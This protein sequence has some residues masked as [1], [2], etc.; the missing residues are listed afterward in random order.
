MART[1]EA[2]ATYHR[3]K[4][5]LTEHL[6]VATA[7]LY[8]LRRNIQTSNAP[9][10]LGSFVDACGVQHWGKGKH[11]N[12]ADEKVDAAVASLAEQGVIQ[13]V[14]AFDL[15][16]RNLIQDTARFSSQAR[17]TLS[18][19]K[20]DHQLL[21]LSSAN[22][23]VSNHC[24][25]DLSGRLDTLSKRLEELKLWL[26]WAPSAKLTATLPL[27]ELIRGIRNRIAHD[28][29]VIGADLQ[30]LA[31]SEEIMTA[32]TAF[33]AKYAKRDV[34]AI[35]PFKRGQRLNLMTVHAILFG[36]FLYEIAKELNAHATSLL[37]DADYI[38]MAFYYS[39][40]VEEHPFR[41]MRHRSAA[42]R[43]AYFLAERYWRANAA[44]GA[45]AITRRLAGE[46][47]VD[48]SR[49]KFNSSLWRVALLRH[50]ELL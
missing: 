35:P 7:G 4:E 14:A 42:H 36:A 25:H 24:C 29:G 6:Q 28:N 8:L 12:R 40:V 11:Y 16:T 33:R 22:R 10:L 26:G 30:E 3:K 23:W 21:R 45:S 18:H 1:I 17:N 49:P 32:L 31:A 15:F 37:A 50:Q 46:M 41:T 5:L 19:C 39:C 20:H 34:P 47:L 2:Y 48:S 9:A 43:I 27:F 38:D 44:P 13:H